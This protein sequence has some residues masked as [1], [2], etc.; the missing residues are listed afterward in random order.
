VL[1]L[2]ALVF[3]GLTVFALLR[4]FRTRPIA[5]LHHLGQL[6]RWR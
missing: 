4:L 1:E 6:R 2:S 3:L 5:R